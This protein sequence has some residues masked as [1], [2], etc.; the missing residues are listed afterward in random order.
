MKIPFC[1]NPNPGLKKPEIEGTT[2]S[3]RRSRGEGKNEEK[4]KT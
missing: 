1:E 3:E 4:A 2:L